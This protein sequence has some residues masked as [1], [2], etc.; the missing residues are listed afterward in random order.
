MGLTVFLMTGDIEAK[1][2]RALL[3]KHEHDIRSSMLLAPHHGSGSS[4]TVALA[5][6]S[7][8]NT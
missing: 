3:S 8:L 1:A 6:P 2:E 4:S 5:G 7:P